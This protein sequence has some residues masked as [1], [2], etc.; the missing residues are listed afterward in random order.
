MMKHK[1]RF[2]MRLCL[3]PILCCLLVGCNKKSQESDVVSQRYVHK[4]GYAVSQDEFESRKYPGQSIT[5]LKNGVTITTTY[6]NGVLHGSTTHTFPHSQTIETYL[7]YNQGTLVKEI[8]YDINGM[9]LRQEVQLSPTRY[10]TTKWYADGIPMSSEEYAGIELVEAQYFTPQ[11]DIEARVEKGRGTR[12]SRDIHGILVSR[13]EIDE[14]VITKRETFYAS[15]APETIAYYQNGKL[16]GE[17][18]SFN[19]SGEPLAIKEYIIGKLHGKTTFF[20]NGARSLEIHY[21]DGL[22]N[23]LE[24]HY[25]DGEAVSQ[26]IVWENDKKHGPATYYVDGVPQVEFYYDGALVSEDRWKELNRLDEIIGQI[27]PD[28]AW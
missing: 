3:F 16:H 13:E 14:G 28:V 10:A 20:K 11:N 6:E 21:L 26:Q 12:I 27:S 25:L 15:G 23:G 9:P 7:L 2:S 19:E 5:M 8:V 4:Y 24:I 1:G 18:K 17:K 22:K